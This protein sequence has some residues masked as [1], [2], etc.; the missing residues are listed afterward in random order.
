MLRCLGLP[1]FASVGGLMHY[2][3]EGGEARVV[4]VPV[5]EP[6]ASRHRIEQ[7]LSLLQ[8]A[9]VEA[10]RKPAVDWSE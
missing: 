1:R 7:N 6:S 3:S 9:S 4:L 8:I 2:F 10:F 5:Q